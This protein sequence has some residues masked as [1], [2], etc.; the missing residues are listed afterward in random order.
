MNYWDSSS[1]HSAFVSLESD[2]ICYPEAFMPISVLEL[3]IMPK[4]NLIK[5][6]STR[7][8]LDLLFEN[9][10]NILKI[11][12]T[13]INQKNYFNTVAL[14]QLLSSYFMLLILEFQIKERKYLDKKSIF[15]KINKNNSHFD[16]LSILSKIREKWP[17]NDFSTNTGIS[18]NLILKIMQ[19]VE[20]M[21]N[22][23]QSPA[24][25]K[26]VRFKYFL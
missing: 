26:E 22:N 12:I 13:L 21:T 8:S 25:L 7:D 5:V 17:S 18:E 9:Y 2:L 4:N 20:I 24:L 14:K 6:R 15:K 3:G 11:I 19:Q 10:F 1:H 16:L 23:I